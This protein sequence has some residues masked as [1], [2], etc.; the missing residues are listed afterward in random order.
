MKGLVF[1]S[2]LALPSLVL[3]LTP[4]E[5]ALRIKRLAPEAGVLF[6]EEDGILFA[7]NEKRLYS[8]ASCIKIPLLLSAFN[9]LGEDFRFRTRFYVDQENNL[10]IR[11]DGDPFLTSEEL[12]LVARNLTARGRSAFNHLYLDDSL[13][14]RL[15][16][17]GL[18]DSDNPYDARLSSLMANFNT[19]NLL[20]RPSGQVM[21]AEPQTPSLPLAQLMKDRL[22]CCDEPT[23][24]NLR[25]EREHIRRHTAELVQ[26]IFTQHG[27]RLKKGYKISWLNKDWS[28][29]YT[30]KNSRSLARVGS[31]LFLYS[32]NLI[33]NAL[34]LQFATDAHAPLD[35]A[36]SVWRA[37]LK[38]MS[39]MD[40]DVSEG[41]GLDERNRFSP[42]SMHQV[43]SQF[44][45]RMDMLPA[46]HQGAFYKTGSLT[47]VS[48]A[49]GYIIKE[50]SRIRP[51]VIFSTSYKPLLAILKRID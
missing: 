32:N 14:Q 41:S 2:L 33:A 11:G 12:I 4:E 35:S 5:A 15:R 38:R 22:A 25:G 30:H 31:E 17:P 29:I 8:I 40:F 46:D 51:F 44:K 18:G 43:L 1:L 50:D 27:I 47:G 6:A 36:L 28:L 10:L 34:L 37:D 16:L 48:N 21:S 45:S 42:L 20:R 24:I 9:R 13:Y 19:M 49:A 39:V 26:A 7:Q 23:R 3:G